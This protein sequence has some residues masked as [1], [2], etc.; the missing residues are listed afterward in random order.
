MILYHTLH[1]LVPSYHITNPILAS[2]VQRTV[3]QA[4]A[5]YQ[6]SA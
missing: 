4:L 5:D 3:D 1:L 6:R 2:I